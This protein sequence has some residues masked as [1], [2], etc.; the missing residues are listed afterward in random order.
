MNGVNPLLEFDQTTY[1]FTLYSVMEDHSGV[2]IGVPVNCAYA[3]K[4]SNP[5]EDKD[6]GV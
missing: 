5:M 6:I 3:L 1:M 2:G 4:K